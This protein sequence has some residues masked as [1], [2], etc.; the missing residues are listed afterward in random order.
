[1]KD[2]I[3]STFF[4]LLIL[5]SFNNKAEDS[6]SEQ[7]LK[8]AFIGQ[9]SHYINWPDSPKKL[10][11]AYLGN[12]DQYWQALQNMTS[13]GASKYPLTLNRISKPNMYF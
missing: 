7:T 1:M 6:I 13:S 5:S 11:L 9:F 3:F 10:N 8:S 4:I 2:I 12:D